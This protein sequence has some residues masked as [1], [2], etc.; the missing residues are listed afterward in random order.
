MNTDNSQLNANWN[1]LTPSVRNLFR[2]MYNRIL[3]RIN[4]NEELA[5]DKG[6][7]FTFENQFGKDN[8]LTDIENINAEEVAPKWY[9]GM[10]WYEWVQLILFLILGGVV[11]HVLLYILYW[12]WCLLNR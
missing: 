11:L 2:R 7:K 6:L 4:K 12:V 9:K 5:G 1:S 3:E 10:K 8:L